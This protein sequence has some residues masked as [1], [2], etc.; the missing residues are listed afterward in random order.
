M[1]GPAGL[2]RLL[3]GVVEDS[4][5]LSLAQHL[6]VHG[7]PQGRDGGQTLTAVEAAGLRGR[8]GAGFPTARKMASVAS[9]RGLRGSVLVANGAEGEP[10]SQKDA[11]LLSRTPHLVLDGMAAAAAVIGARRAVLC[12]HEGS[13]CIGWVSDALAERRAAGTDRLPVELEVIPGR[14]V[15]ARS[16]R[17]STG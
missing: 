6:Q 7:R 9:S 4:G 1:T 8:G 11:F 15:A 17:S 14:Y 5:P 2:P 12:L 3:S 10:L 16:P 13:T